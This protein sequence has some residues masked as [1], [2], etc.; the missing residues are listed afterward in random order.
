MNKKLTHLLYRIIES[1]N[2]KFRI[3]S[4][5]LTDLEKA[6]VVDQTGHADHSR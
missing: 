3:L 6:P 2:D 1:V 4:I 5:P